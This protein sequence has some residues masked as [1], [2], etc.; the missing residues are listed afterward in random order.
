MGSI[1]CLVYLFHLL[2]NNL[3]PCLSYVKSVVIVEIVPFCIC[4]VFL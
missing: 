1:I 2:V 4:F 3:V